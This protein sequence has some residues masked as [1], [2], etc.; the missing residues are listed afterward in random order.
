MRKLWALISSRTGRSVVAVAVFGTLA[1]GA[2]NLDTRT[3]RQR[4][5]V[6]AASHAS[7]QAMTL[8]ALA[9]YPAEYRQAI[10][11]QLPPAEQS[12]L[13]HVQLQRVLDTEA[14]LTGDQRAFLG[15]V[16]TMATPASFM[17]EMPKPEVCQDIARL[18]T[19]PKQKERVRTI[20]AGVAPVSTVTSTWVSVTER[21]RA[22]VSLRADLFPCSCRGQGL[23]ECGLVVACVTGDCTHTQN[24]GCIWSGECDK[25]CD[26]GLPQMNKV[27]AK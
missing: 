7:G 15:R 11:D 2:V 18:F 26:G 24:C 13:W 1:V 25:M 12:R 21:L 3:V 20:A 4:A 8:E 9:A 23:C 17:K 22:A 19:N 27:T 6:W 14:N 5:D 10:F 16:M